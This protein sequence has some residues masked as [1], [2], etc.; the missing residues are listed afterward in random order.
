[1]ISALNHD[2]PYDEFVRAQILGNR[3][4][5][6]HTTVNGAAYRVEGSAEDHVR[7][8]FLA[9]AALT[10]NDKDHDI[11][12]RRGGDYFDCVHGHDR[13]LREMPRP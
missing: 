1:M 3:Y 13:G 10:R 7:A 9:R 6:R 4:K 8:G 2:M 12:L 5:P 11:P